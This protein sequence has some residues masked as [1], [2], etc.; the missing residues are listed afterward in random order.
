MKDSQK[1]KQDLDTPPTDLNEIIMFDMDN[2]LT[3]ASDVIEDC[4][5]PYLVNLRKKGYKL[6]IVTR[7]SQEKLFN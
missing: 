6:G 7:A 2:T 1:P 4:M 3:P 5:I